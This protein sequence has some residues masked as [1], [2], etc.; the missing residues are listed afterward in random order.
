MDDPLEPE[1]DGQH[2][3]S[4][5]LPSLAQMQQSLVTAL[6]VLR[7]PPQ[8][9]GQFLNTASATVAGIRATLKL[10]ARDLPAL[11]GKLAR[12]REDAARLATE[13]QDHGFAPIAEGCRMLVD[14]ITELQRLDAISGDAMLP[15]AVLVDRVAASVG[16]VSR[17]EEQRYK[18]AEP[19]TQTRRRSMPPTDW[20]LASER[21]WRG[22]LHSRSELVGVMIKLH[23]D[24]AAAVPLDCGARSMNCCNTCCAMPWTMASS[25]PNSAWPPAN[26]PWVI[27]ACCSRPS[28]P[29]ALLSR[30]AMTDVA[31]TVSHAMAAA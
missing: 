4:Q 15:L 7:A 29:A 22:F 11:R 26:Q 31:S 3:Q 2:R 13:A 14:R 23:M 12:L 16:N 10:P 30:C 9:I 21:R 19:A 6:S 25:R 17:V 8:I 1:L 5:T 27:S 28:A 18:P 20:T 24:G